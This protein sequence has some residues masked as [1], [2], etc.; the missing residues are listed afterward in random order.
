MSNKNM[1]LAA[2]ALFSM[3][4][5]GANPCNKVSIKEVRKTKSESKKCKSC[6]YFAYGSCSRYAIPN[7]ENNPLHVAC[8]KYV[9]RKR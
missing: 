5:S 2:S 8:D 9:K 3:M 6:K 4:S 1:I 7:Y